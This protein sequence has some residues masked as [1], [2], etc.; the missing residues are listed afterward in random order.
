[1]EFD[2]HVEKDHFCFYKNS[3][4][5]NFTFINS[6]VVYFD[7]DLTSTAS[8]GN[9]VYT[10]IKCSLSPLDNY[11]C[12][13]SSDGATLNLIKREISDLGVFEKAVK[14]MSRKEVL[15]NLLQTKEFNLWF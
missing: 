5:R 7:K 2:I 3:I 14:V 1:M 10:A 15:H 6:K 8:L 9:E 12:S 4:N 13:R 11:T